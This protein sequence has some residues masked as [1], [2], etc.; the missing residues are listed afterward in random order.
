MYWASVM[1]MAAGAA[2]RAVIDGIGV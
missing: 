2:L 1:A